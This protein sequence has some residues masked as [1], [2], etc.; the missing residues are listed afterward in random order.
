[1]IVTILGGGAF[2]TPS[3]VDWLARQ[4]L[5]RP[6][7]IRLAGRTREN[8]FAVARASRLLAEGSPLQIEIFTR[9]AWEQALDST[10]VTLIQLRVGGLE[11]RDFDETFPHSYCIPGDEGLGP[12]GLSS[13][14]RTW[15]T[16]REV[17]SLAHTAAPHSLPL[18]LTSPGSLLIRLIA[19]EFPNLRAYGICEL[20]FTTLKAICAASLKEVHQVGFNYSGVN[21]LG[22]LHGIRSEG[23]DLIGAYREQQKCPFLRRCIDEYHAVP[24]KYFQLYTEPLKMAGLQRENPSRARQLMTIQRTAIETFPYA[25]ADGIRKLLSLRP[26][27]WYSEAVGPLLLQFLNPSCNRF[28]D[29]PFFLSTA[30]STGNVEEKA[31][32]FHNQQ[33]Q[34][35]P[36]SEAPPSEVRRFN[37]RYMEYER[38]AAAT[39]ENPTQAKLVTT[40][41]THPWISRESDAKGLAGLIWTHFQQ[42]APEKN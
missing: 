17:V 35:M 38:Q 12:G 6:L 21:H 4:N 39:V 40:L 3:L 9:E 1:M 36:T 16:L 31:F 32:V 15:P 34:L 37:D 11:S 29:Q 22:W 2:S 18:L 23:I 24:M 7:T 25:Q 33:F 20:P 28:F 10:D 14:L 27:P 26:T 30:D 19:H 8:L 5:E 41:K 13:A 42:F